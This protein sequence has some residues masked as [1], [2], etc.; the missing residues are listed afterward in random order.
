MT[1]RDDLKSLEVSYMV[2]KDQYAELAKALGFEGD[3]FFGDPLADHQAIV[4]KAKEVM[5]KAYR[6]DSVNK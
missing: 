1:L 5:E 3:A 4:D 6:Y 2:I